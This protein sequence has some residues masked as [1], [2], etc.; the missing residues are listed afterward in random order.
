MQGVFINLNKY[1]S[2][3]ALEQVL[4][5]SNLKREAIQMQNKL[6]RFNFF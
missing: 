5:N 4:I 6:N 3:S 2:K 1:I